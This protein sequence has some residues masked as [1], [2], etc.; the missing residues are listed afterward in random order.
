[1]RIG[2]ALDERRNERRVALRPEELMDIA[3]RHQVFVERGAGLGVGISDD[4]YRQAGAHP[5]AKA[6]VYS[7]PLVVKLREP[8]EAELKLMRPGSTVFSMMHLHNRLNLARL[9][10]RMRIN[11]IAMERVKDH[12]G[13]RMIE[14]LHEVGYCGMQKAFELWGRNPAKA[15]VK[16]MGY[17]KIALGAIQAA[18]RAQARVILLNKREM[19]Q[20]ER[21]LPGT[22]LLVDGLSWPAELR[23]KLFLVTRG[24]LR[25]M[26]PRAAVI[27]LVSNPIGQYP[28]ETMRP[29]TLSDISYVDHGVTHAACWGWS[30]LDPVNVTRRFSIQIAPVLDD[31]SR[32][33]I[34]RLPPYI[35]QALTRGE[36]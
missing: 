23:G 1:M 28:I 33:G 29:T 26:N 22:D 6:L 20:M 21:H 2:L 3:R 32:H 18:S 8:N 17:G 10:R 5:A 24:M 30:G 14:D 16:I 9:L 7:C 31:I 19:N 11:A 34:A 36:L 27:G 13:E 4:E 15:T 35:G 12:L 25:L